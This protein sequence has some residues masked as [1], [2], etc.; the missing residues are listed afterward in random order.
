MEQS[1]LSGLKNGF[2]HVRKEESEP[3]RKVITWEEV[4]EIS[5]GTTPENNAGRSSSNTV[6]REHTEGGTGKD[7]SQA[8]SSKARPS[9]STTHRT[10][11]T[12]KQTTL[13]ISGRK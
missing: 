13:R 10:S 4:D 7:R 8:N 5:G 3:A 6:D 1:N 11:K 12:L 9:H 2:V